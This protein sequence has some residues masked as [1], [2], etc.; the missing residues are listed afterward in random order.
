M[1]EG[2]LTSDGFDSAIMIKF[3]LTTESHKAG[4][5]GGRQAVDAVT[6]ATAA[7]GSLETTPQA[8]DQLGSVVDTGTTII[9]EAQTFETA[10]GI[11]LKRMALFNKIVA[12]IAAVF[13]LH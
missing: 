3:S 6:K 10:W 11:L 4:D 7:L 2:T 13:D 12:D 1:F 9:T 5:A 8:F